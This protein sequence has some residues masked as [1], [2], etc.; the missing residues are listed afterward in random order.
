MDRLEEVWWRL[1][2][3]IKER[4]VFLG[5]KQTEAAERAGVSVATWRLLESGARTAYRPL[6]LKAVQRA[7]EWSVSI[8][9]GVVEQPNFAVEAPA[10]RLYEELSAR[11]HELQATRERLIEAEVAVEGDEGAM[12]VHLPEEI[13]RRL[14][15]M[16][17]EISNLFARRSRYEPA[18]DIDPPAAVA[19]EVP[20]EMAALSGKL[21][22]LT[23]KERAAVETLI[24]TMLEDD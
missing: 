23:A 1:G 16:D 4:R 22:R 8:P 19:L 3:L 17:Y 6:T 11:I 2:G 18:D 12:S 21:E 15:E 24:D 14:T 5:M 10:P 20:L 9:A 13:V 7:L